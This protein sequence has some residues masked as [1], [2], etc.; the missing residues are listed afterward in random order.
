VQVGDAISLKTAQ[1]MLSMLRGVVDGGTASGIRR[2]FRYDAAGKTGTTNNFADAWF[3]GVTPQLVAGVWTGFD[4]R[5]IQFTGD[6]G[7]GGR[8]S[9]PVWGRMMQKIYNDP[10]LAFKQRQFTVVADS[11]DVVDPELIL[12]PPQDQIS[13]PLP[14]TLA[15]KQQR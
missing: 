10:Q 15:T 3:V 8:A 14:D 6:Y 4:D 9:A 11:A 7:Q 1:N 12:N 5:R 13:D 2:Y